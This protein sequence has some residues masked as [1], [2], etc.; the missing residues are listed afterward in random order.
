MT[1]DTSED[2][3][4]QRMLPEQVSNNWE[5]FAPV[6]ERSLPPLVIN[7]RQRMANVLRSILMDELV[8]WLYGNKQELRY[9]ISTVERVDP[10]SLTKDLLIYT[11]T[12]FG[13][14][15]SVDLT[16][17]FELLSRFGKSRGCLSVVAYVDE[18]GILRLLERL[19]AKTNFNLVQMEIL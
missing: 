19:G 17:G 2:F 15:K 14:V 11:F 13:N 3:L 16:E 4:L 5:F 10:V 9:V 6:L 18:P 1:T 8:V 12:G 7:G